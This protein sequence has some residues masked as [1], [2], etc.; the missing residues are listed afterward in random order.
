MNPKDQK[1]HGFGEGLGMG[2]PDSRADRS[3]KPAAWQRFKQ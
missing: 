1:I 2:I 3:P